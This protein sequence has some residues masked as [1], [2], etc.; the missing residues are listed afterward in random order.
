MQ[1][2]HTHTQTHIQP[3][4]KSYAKFITLNSKGTG[5]NKQKIHFATDTP[6]KF[7]RQRIE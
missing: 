7:E 1:H 3:Q 5:H 4:N 6:S 2:S